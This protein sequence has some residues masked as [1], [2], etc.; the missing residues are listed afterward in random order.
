VGSG[1][2][3]ANVT[4]QLYL[5]KIFGR[6]GLRARHPRLASFEMADWIKFLCGILLRP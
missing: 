4:S 5:L 1:W 6:E 2:S 3:G